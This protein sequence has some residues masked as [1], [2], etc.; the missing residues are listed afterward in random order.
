MSAPTPPRLLIGRVRCAFDGP[1]LAK[2]CD[3]PKRS[4]PVQEVPQQSDRRGR[5]RASPLRHEV[6]GQVPLLIAACI[7]AGGGA[8]SAAARFILRPQRPEWAIGL[9]PGATLAM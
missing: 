4:A 7:V 3:I 2:K 9:P 8:G 5:K 6:G 1:A